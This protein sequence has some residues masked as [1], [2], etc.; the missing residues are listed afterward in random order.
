MADKRITFSCTGL[1]IVHHITAS[2]RGV[3]GTVRLD[4]QY[5]EA[6]P[7][8]ITL[9]VH[10]HF[11]GEPGTPQWRFARELL[12][13]GRCEPAGSGDVR[14]APK[15]GRFV[16][17]TLR[18]RATG[19]TLLVSVDVPAVEAALDATEQ[20]VPLGF[21]KHLGP[22]SAAVDAELAAILAGG[23]R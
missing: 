9:V 13:H 12:D 11:R 1:L 16:E 14:V 7:A 17:I 6:D 21:E 23:A 3:G 8:A 2:Q 18:N 19:R 10:A 5:D 20:L 4:F 22:D 15:I